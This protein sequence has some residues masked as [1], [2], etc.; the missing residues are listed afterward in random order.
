[1]AYDATHLAKLSALKALAEKVKADYATKKELSTLSNKVEGLITTGGQ[2]NIIEGVKVNGTLLDLTEKI[3]NILIAEGKTNGTIAANGVD[4]PVHGLAALA[5]KAEVSEAE[6]AKALKDAIAA[7]AKQADLDTLTGEG[8][9]SIKKM[10]DDAFNDFAT[11]VSDDG[12]VNSYKELIDWA[13]THGAEATKLTN[14]ISENKTAI[15]NLK[16]Y[17][18][19]LPE[20]ATA[21][22][23][24]GYIAEAIAAL[25]IGDYA[26]T[27]EVTSAINTALADYYK[28]TDVDTA[29]G[30][31][32]DKVS[33]ATAGN[34]AGLDANGNLTDSGKKAADF[35]AAEAGKR[36]MTDAE[37][38][39]LGGIQDGATKVET[40]ETNGNV[41]INGVEK[42]V[43]TLPT[44]VV[45]GAIATDDEVTEML[46]EVFGAAQV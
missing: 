38:T 46:N 44:N 13:A 22:D 43:Y 1:M 4:I 9:G 31:K 32:A 34:F 15:A 5:Y 25:S 8:E 39:K 41:K 23:V 21:T 17:V 40:S 33:K 24:V 3:A 2:P 12:V 35:V 45:K 18:G 26:K 27:T 20:G 30:K 11:K 10:I 6:L 29:L 42:T 7:K 36:L 19:T 28:K 14:G 37:G 16:K